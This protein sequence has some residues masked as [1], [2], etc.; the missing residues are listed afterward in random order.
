MV[1]SIKIL[2]TVYGGDGMGRLGDGRVVFVP[3]TF[4]GEQVKAEI[5]A[6]KKNFVK[7]RLIEI[8]ESSPNRTGN[9]EVPV[10]GAVFWNLSIPTITARSSPTKSK[11]R[12]ILS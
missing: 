3:D 6:E 5:I 12:S 11:K 7:A 2:K 9:G 4:A 8:E 1:S 10:P